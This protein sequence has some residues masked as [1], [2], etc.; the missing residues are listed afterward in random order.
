ML[1]PECQEIIEIADVEGLVRALHLQNEC[2]V[3]NLFHHNE[4]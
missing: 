4:A 1:C 3:S 2:V